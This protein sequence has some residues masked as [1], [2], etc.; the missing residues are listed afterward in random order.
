M[1]NYG[2]NAADIVQTYT[3]AS[4]IVFYFRNVYIAPDSEFEV[5][6]RTNDVTESVGV[7]NQAHRRKFTL[8]M[9]AKGWNCTMVTFINKSGDS[10]KFI[11]D[12]SKE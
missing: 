4:D 2:N 11:F 10:F 3:F 6:C 12:G 1:P 5:K 9:P 8:P 7:F